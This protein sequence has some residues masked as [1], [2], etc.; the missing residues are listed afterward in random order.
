MKTETLLLLVAVAAVAFVALKP[1]PAPATMVTINKPADWR[2]ELAKGAAGIGTGVV[3]LFGGPKPEAE[4][5]G[6][7]GLFPNAR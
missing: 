7:F 2:A 5:S 4:G 6:F 1:K 3:G